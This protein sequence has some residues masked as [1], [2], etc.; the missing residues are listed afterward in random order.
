MTRWV[1]LRRAT[2]CRPTL[3]SFTEGYLFLTR[4]LGISYFFLSFSNSI[5][6]VTC[7]EERDEGRP[8]KRGTEIKEGEIKEGEM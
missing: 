3:I 4:R 8:V 2:N 7:T 1:L 5:D 6:G